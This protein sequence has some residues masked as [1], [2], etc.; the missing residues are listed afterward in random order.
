MRFLEVM[1]IFTQSQMALTLILQILHSLYKALLIAQD[2]N[3][4][5][6]TKVQLCIFAWQTLTEI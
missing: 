3:V 1:G 4:W 2:T 5:L 6:A